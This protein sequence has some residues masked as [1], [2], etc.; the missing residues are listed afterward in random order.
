MK[1]HKYFQLSVSLRGKKIEKKFPFLHD[2]YEVISATIYGHNFPR[3][4]I[5][6][7]YEM[8]K[9]LK[10]WALS[11]I[12]TLTKTACFIIPPKYSQKYK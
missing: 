8:F 12:Q 2:E 5:E 3:I 7:D 4:T 10:N 9:L 6:L 11:N 1:Q